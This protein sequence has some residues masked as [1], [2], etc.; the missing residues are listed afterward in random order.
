MVLAGTLCERTSLS[1]AAKLRSRISSFEEVI[2]L[3]AA[4]EPSYLRLIELYRRQGREGEVELVCRGLVRNVPTSV[5]GFNELAVLLTDRRD[6]LDAALEAATKA[7][8]IEP[9]NGACLDTL[10]WVYYQRGSFKEAATPLR[11]GAALSPQSPV[12][13]YHVGAALVKAGHIEEGIGH[14]R[15]SIALAPDSKTAK[16]AEGLLAESDTTGSVRRLSELRGVPAL[17]KQ[18]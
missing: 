4:N 1:L 15:Q 11:K 3:D 14:L 6:Q 12:I 2:K 18:F 13:R 8:A 17:A 5:V 9:E 16:L 10:G 7:V